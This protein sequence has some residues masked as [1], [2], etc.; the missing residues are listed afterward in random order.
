MDAYATKI[1]PI[2]YVGDR[3]RKCY[4]VV[5][6]ASLVR[7]AKYTPSSLYYGYNLSGRSP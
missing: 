5:Q 7:H 1:A 3:Q 2:E 4:H 6:A